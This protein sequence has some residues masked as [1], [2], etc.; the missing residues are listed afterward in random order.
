VVFPFDPKRKAASALRL[1]RTIRRDR[2]ALV[3]ME[4]T[5][6][7]GGIPLLLARCLLRT[8]YVV[9]AG[10]AV[11]P[12]IGSQRRAL[13]PVAWIYEML[14]LRYCAACIGWTPYLVGRALTFG[15]PRAAT[16]PGRSGH[17]PRP[18]ARERIRADLGI[19]DDA[20]VFGIVGSLQW[21]PRVAYTYG[22]ELVRAVTRT[23]RADIAVVIVGDGSGFA[24]LKEMAGADLGTRVKLVGWVAHDEVPD[25][26]A[27]FDVASL[28]QSCDQVGA[29]RYSTKLPEYL[30]A[31]L[32]IVIGELPVAYDLT[33]R[34]SWRLPGAAPWTDEY[35]NAMS[36]LMASISASDVADRRPRTD[37]SGASLFAL[38]SQRERVGSLVRDLLVG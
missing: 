24:R 23:T 32:P 28:P 13:G 1:L 26:L 12:Y 15:A 21:T 17:E 22:A 14:L 11:G 31:E 25:Y 7:A 36:A 8:R 3:V 27:A 30:A 34:C 35:V 20:I 19:E 9:I 2:S 18:G 5:G 33:L 4:G 10:D 6:I 37:E 38:E 16:A 29:F